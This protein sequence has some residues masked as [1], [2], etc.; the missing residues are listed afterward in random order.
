MGQNMHPQAGSIVEVFY[1]MFIPIAITF[2]WRNAVLH[3]L[4]HKV[5]FFI[6]SSDTSSNTI[7]TA[8]SF[9]STTSSF[10]FHAAFNASP[11]LNHRVRRKCGSFSS[12]GLVLHLNFLILFADIATKRK[13]AGNRYQKLA[14]AFL[15]EHRQL[16]LHDLK[17][18]G[19]DATFA[20]TFPK[21]LCPHSSAPWV[22]IYRTW[23]VIGAKRLSWKSPISSH[24]F[25]IFCGFA[26]SFAT[27]RHDDDNEFAE[28]QWW[29]MQWWNS[30]SKDSIVIAIWPTTCVCMHRYDTRIPCNIKNL[31]ILNS[32][33]PLQTDMPTQV[34]IQK[35]LTITAETH[36]KAEKWNKKIS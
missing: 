33:Q 32:C 6:I 31:T 36:S 12:I 3:L 35:K 30:S 24:W 13:L 25:F 29:K 18:S 20:L 22:T 28:M 17:Q 7:T 4:S 8:S 27:I 5:F 1:T 14:K 2:T 15:C 34:E 10:G 19:R 23:P 11:H 21:I 16:V 26:T 9:G